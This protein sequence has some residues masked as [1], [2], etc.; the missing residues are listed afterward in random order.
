MKAQIS[1]AHAAFGDTVDTTT[2]KRSSNKV[3]KSTK[4]LSVKIKALANMF[5]KKTA[6]HHDLVEEIASERKENED[7]LKQTTMSLE[8]NL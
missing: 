5:K 1:E 2:R 3:K 4:S 6:E 7:M 8:T